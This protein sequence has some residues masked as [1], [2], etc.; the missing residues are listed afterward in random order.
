MRKKKRNGP[1]L[2]QKPFLIPLDEEERAL[3]RRDHLG[4]RELKDSS[5]NSIKHEQSNKKRRGMIDIIS[6]QIRV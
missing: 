2:K 3:L 1:G 6:V 4:A 5:Q